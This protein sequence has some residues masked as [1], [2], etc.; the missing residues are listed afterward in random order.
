MWLSG[1]HLGSLDGAQALLHPQQSGCSLQTSW[2]ELIF[3]YLQ[4][5]NA[6]L[7]GYCRHYLEAISPR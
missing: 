7:P 6:S 2:Q 1:F 3:R 5:P 4:N